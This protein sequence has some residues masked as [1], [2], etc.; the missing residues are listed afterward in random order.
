MLRA[1]Y[2]RVWDFLGQPQDGDRPAVT[3]DDVELER[4]AVYTFKSKVATKWR[5]GRMMIAGD[6]AHL[7]PPFM[8]REY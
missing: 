1:V 2:R 6:A 4:I 3:P 8:G 5:V 7:T